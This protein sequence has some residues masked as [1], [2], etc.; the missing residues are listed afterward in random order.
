MALKFMF[1]APRAC[2]GAAATGRKPEPRIEPFLH[3]CRQLQYNYMLINIISVWWPV[4]GVWGGCHAWF[5]DRYRGGV[6]GKTNE[7][8]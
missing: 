6:P 2:E 7:I 1:A 8:L 3:G 4:G 5:P